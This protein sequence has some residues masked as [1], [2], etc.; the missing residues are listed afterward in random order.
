MGD[1]CWSPARR[2][3]GGG[4][5]K[6]RLQRLACEVQLPCAG[7]GKGRPRPLHPRPGALPLGT[8]IRCTHLP[9]AGRACLWAN[10]SGSNDPDLSI[11]DTCDGAL[12]VRQA[13]F[14]GGLGAARP[15]SGEREGQ[16]PLACLTSAIG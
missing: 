7:G 16:S 12:I 9:S 11:P 14:A 3:A 2:A 8:P 13:S 15:P 5:W 4:P 10:V 6:S 1:G